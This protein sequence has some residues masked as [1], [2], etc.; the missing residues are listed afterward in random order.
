MIHNKYSVHLN[1]TKVSM[2]K[3]TSQEKNYSIQYHP[4][5]PCCGSELFGSPLDLTDCTDYF[6]FSEKEGMIT[7]YHI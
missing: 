2:R 7:V 1:G 4:R 5:E 3:S 6:Y